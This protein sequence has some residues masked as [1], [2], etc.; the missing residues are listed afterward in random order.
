MRRP[1]LPLLVLPLLGAA[2]LFVVLNMREKEAEQ[3]KPTTAPATETADAGARGGARSGRPPTPTSVTEF[4]ALSELERVMDR[5]DRSNARWFISHIAMDMEKVTGNETYARRLLDLLRTRG[6]DSE[7]LQ[8][9]DILLPILRV[10]EHPEATKMVEEGFFSAKNEDERMMFLE[11]MSHPYHNPD[12]ASFLAVDRA[13]HAETEEHRYRS[14]DVVYRYTGD[15]RLVFRAAKSIYEGTVRPEQSAQVLEAITYAAFAVPEA[16][17]WIRG[18]LKSPRVED[19]HLLMNSV[20]AW[21]NPIDAAQ[22]EALA[23]E[24]PALGDQLREKAD[25]IRMRLRHE[26]QA[27]SGQDPTGGEGRQRPPPG[28]RREGEAPPK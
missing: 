19:L 20:E 25:A 11:A 4:E 2:V 23:N 18:R 15:F 24:F 22:L 12:K 17:E 9:R 10:F 8:D 6:M 27:K 14:F 16:Q 1:A 5:P 7:D 21:G 28:S 3:R 26:Q 13:L